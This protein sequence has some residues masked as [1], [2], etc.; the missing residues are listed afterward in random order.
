MLTDPSATTRAVRINDHVGGSK[1]FSNISIFILTFVICGYV[2]SINSGGSGIS[3]GEIVAAHDH[4]QTV[5]MGQHVSDSLLILARCLKGD[6]VTCKPSTIF[7]L[8]LQ[9]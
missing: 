5:G 7:N 8:L 3:V 9:K 4:G 6:D 1:T 2:H